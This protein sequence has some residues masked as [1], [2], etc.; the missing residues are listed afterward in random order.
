MASMSAGRI[1]AAREWLLERIEI[2]GRTLPGSRMPGFERLTPAFCRAIE[3][4]PDLAPLDRLE[5][6]MRRVIEHAI[7]L[8]QPVGAR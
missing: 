2:E 4:L 1:A 6:E 8:H 5:T 7:G 3:S